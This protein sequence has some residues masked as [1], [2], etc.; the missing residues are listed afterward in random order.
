MLYAAN[1]STLFTVA[2]LILP[3]LKDVVGLLESQLGES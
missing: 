2:Q 1:W 3:H